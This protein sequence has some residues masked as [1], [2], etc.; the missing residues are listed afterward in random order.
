[1]KIIPASAFCIFLILP[2]AAWSQDAPIKVYFAPLIASLGPRGWLDVSRDNNLTNAV[3][4]ALS[5]A[6]FTPVSNS[7]PEALTLTAPDGVSRRKD[8]YLFTVVF[9][10]DGEKLGEAV[11][12]CPIKDLTDCT[13][14]LVLDTKTAAQ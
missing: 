4:A 5:Q 7:N 11:E 9:S 14:Q 6:P 13:N 2:A 12:S 10:R 3:R 8:E 1:M